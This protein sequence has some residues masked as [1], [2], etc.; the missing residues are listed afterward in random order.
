MSD[1]AYFRA[2]LWTWCAD[3]GCGSR[4][5]YRKSG[6]VSEWETAEEQSQLCLRICGKE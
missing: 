1:A 3:T 5:L 4:D 2:E 6:P